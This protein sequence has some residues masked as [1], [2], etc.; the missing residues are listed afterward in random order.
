MTSIIII[1]YKTINYLTRC[2]ASIK[3]YFINNDF[4]I[5]IID[6]NSGAKEVERLKKE[7]IGLENI[8][9]IFSN[10]NLGFG[11]GNNLGALNAVGDYFFFINSDIEF[12]EDSLRV[13]KARFELLSVRNKIAF[14]QPRLVLGNGSTQ[15]TCTAH[16]T[17]KMILAE[18]NNL[19]RFFVKRD[20]S[21]FRYL[22]WSRDSD[23]EVGAV[24]GAAMFCSAKIF[25][26]IGKFDERFFLYFEEYDLSLRARH[27]CNKSFFINDTHAI[28]YHNSSPSPNINK[29]IIYIVSLIK[30]IFKFYV[31]KK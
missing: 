11:G 24:C 3:K 5:V 17:L 26:K 1:N 15:Q 9:I 8:K 13:L 23:K 25:K 19:V 31:F 7:F 20:Y 12:V 29:R 10:K 16:P 14:L 18:N 27:F 21:L 28:H 6:N 2:V 4:E 30:F 22:D